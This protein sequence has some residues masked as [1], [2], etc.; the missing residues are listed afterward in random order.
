M[1][2]P[3]LPR[4]A[5]VADED[6]ANDDGPTNYRLD[7]FQGRARQL[8]PSATGRATQPPTAGSASSTTEHFLGGAVLSWSH[9][10]TCPLPLW[11]P[12]SQPLPTLP[13]LDSFASP[14]WPLGSSMA[15]SAQ[16]LSTPSVSAF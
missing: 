16:V 15:T 13:N 14:C 12:N 9:P 7:H 10:P 6:G 8:T 1:R 2:R 3:P 11:T 5:I 4:S